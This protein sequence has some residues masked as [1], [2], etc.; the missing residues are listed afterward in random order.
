MGNWCVKKETCWLFRVKTV[1]LFFIYITFRGGLLV[2]VGVG[3]VKKMEV[4]CCC[5]VMCCD[6]LWGGVLWT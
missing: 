4:M 3:R 2:S 6:V 5:V 1:V